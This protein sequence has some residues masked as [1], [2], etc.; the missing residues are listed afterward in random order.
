MKL[1]TIIKITA[2]A[3]LLVS[4]ALPFIN[5]YEDGYLPESL[6]LFKQ[7]QSQEHANSTVQ[8]S[9]T[10]VGLLFLLTQFASYIGIMLYKSLAKHF[11]LISTLGLALLHPFFGF[12][13][14]GP[15]SALTNSL[16]MITN[17]FLLG[18]LYYKSLQKS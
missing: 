18:I 10:Y 15:L 11:L 7:I 17:G 12:F 2:L 8:R 3:L 16:L 6:A 4:I 14:I 1:N 13:T 9:L 5:Y